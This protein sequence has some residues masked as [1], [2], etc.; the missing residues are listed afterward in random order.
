MTQR[1]KGFYWIWLRDEWVTAWYGGDGF[2]VLGG[3]IETEEALAARGYIIG[4]RT[5]EIKTLALRYPMPLGDLEA[6]APFDFERTALDA[7]LSAAVQSGFARHRSVGQLAA[8]YQALRL[9]SLLPR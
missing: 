3:S 8:E 6:L 7:F 2:E 1:T 4:P 9:A 5:N